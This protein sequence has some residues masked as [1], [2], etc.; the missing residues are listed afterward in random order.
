MNIMDPSVNTTVNIDTTNAPKKTTD[1]SPEEWK[2]YNAERSRASY[3]RN[4]QKI[5]NKRIMKNVIKGTL[6]AERCKKLLDDDE[7][8]KWTKEEKEMLIAASKKYSDLKRVDDVPPNMFN[9]LSSELARESR[10]YFQLLPTIDTTSEAFVDTK[11]NSANKHIS[12]QQIKTA[13]EHL[14]DKDLLIK[15]D[16]PKSE[17]TRAITLQRYQSRFKTLFA[18]YGTNNLLDLYESPDTLNNKLVTSHLNPR[19]IKEYFSVLISLYNRSESID[20]EIFPDLKKIVHEGQIKKLG[21]FM[22]QGI[23]LSKSVDTYRMNTEA[24]YEWKDIKLI[25][26]LVKM[27]HKN[28]SK[29]TNLRDQLILQ[30]YIK[31]SILRDN[32]GNVKVIYQPREQYVSDSSE[33]VF[34][35]NDGTMLFGDFKTNDVYRPFLVHIS[36]DTKDIISKYFAEYRRNFNRDPEFLI[37]KNDGEIYKKGKLSRYINNMFEKHGGVHDFSINDLRHSLATF[38]RYSPV[39]VK[40][41]IA[42]MMQH[43]SGNTHR[44]YERH[45]DNISRFEELTDDIVNDLNR[46]QQSRLPLLGETCLYVLNFDNNRQRQNL[47]VGTLKRN[48]D[49]NTKSSLQYTIIPNDVSL[50]NVNVSFDE[51]GTRFFVL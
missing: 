46:K 35:Y 3:E 6:S 48:N 7:N 15:S 31:E 37:T 40:N 34:F 19:S 10:G 24:Y 47:K 36:A 45:N 38:H 28:D 14:Y 20:E 16:R 17:Q 42:K 51:K 32:L 1:L 30:F 29:M 33:N 9:H 26:R 25:L 49:P 4:K 2:K 39:N 5:S 21:K 11:K 18:I 8:R 41:Y 27:N 13:Y 23:E 44:L 22:R 50:N 43:S 12:Y